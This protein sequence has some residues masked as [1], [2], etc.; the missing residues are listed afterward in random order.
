MKLANA[1]ESRQ[2]TMYWASTRRRHYANLRQACEAEARAIVSRAWR[3]RGC[4]EYW[5]N[6]PEAIHVA[7]KLAI[8]IEREARASMRA[9]AV[10][11]PNAL[12]IGESALENMLD[13]RGLR[14]PLEEIKFGDPNIWREICE[15]T[16]RAAIRAMKGG[17]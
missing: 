10:S 8:R 7:A 11:V 14:E 3:R 6:D 15:E 2:R 16:G 13:R 4:E 9:N 1:I 5:A 17:A 12:K